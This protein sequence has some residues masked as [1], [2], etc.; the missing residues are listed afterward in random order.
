M[1][2]SDMSESVSMRKYNKERQGLIPYTSV[3]RPK[4]RQYL[5]IIFS[6]AKYIQCNFFGDLNINETKNDKLFIQPK[7]TFE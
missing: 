7:N 5:E 3:T 2:L 6:G 1:I 4:V